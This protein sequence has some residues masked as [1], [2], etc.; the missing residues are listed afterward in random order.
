MDSIIVIAMSRYTI[1][2]KY[3]C[4]FREAAMTKSTPEGM[5]AV[6]LSDIILIML[7]TTQTPLTEQLVQL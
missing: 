7:T 3:C 1:N 5:L 2:I 6:Y 4:I